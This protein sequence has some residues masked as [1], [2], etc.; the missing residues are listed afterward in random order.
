MSASQPG[1]GEDRL[2]HQL[3][4][5][6]RHLDSNGDGTGTKNFIANYSAGGVDPVGQEIAFIQPPAGKIYRIARMLVLISGKDTNFK[7]DQYGS[8]NPLTT[9]VQ[10]RIQDDSGTVND[11]TDSL[12][13][14]TNGCW[15][16]VCYDSA[17]YG[18]V[19]SNLNDYL[20]VRWTFENAGQQVRLIGDRNE[21][22]EAVFSDDFTVPASS[23]L[24]KH[25]F[26][27]QGYEEDPA[28]I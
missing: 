23:P 15:A 22:L 10:I 26:M 3:K 19:S 13:I 11:L 17:F 28:E 8:A 4:L 9:G 18:N 27:V 14:Q 2:G 20:R 5:I 21:R 6:S 12:P 24:V 16:R 1:R 7:T 25:Y